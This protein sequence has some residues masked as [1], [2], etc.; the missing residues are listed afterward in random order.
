MSGPRVALRW[1]R[2][3]FRLEVDL[4]LPDR[5]LTALTGPSGS[6]KTTLLRCIAGLER[7]DGRVEFRG[8]VWQAEDRFLPPHRRSVGYVFQ[9]AS[10][11][12]HLDVAGNLRFAL[13][14]ARRRPP[15]LD[16][17]QAVALF[18][19]APLLSRRPA[20]LSGGERQRV[21]LART[22]LVAPEWL[23]MDEP[24]ASLDAQRK[25][26]ILPFLERL[27]ARFA[28]PVLYV[29]HDL[30]EIARLADHLVVLDRGQ[31]VAQGAPADLAA[32]L[33]LVG[34]LGEE[35]AG[36]VEGRVAD[37]DGRWHLLR[38]NFAG[39][40]LWV[41]DGGQALGERVRLRVLARD[42]SVALSP[43]TDS[44]ILNCFPA[45]VEAFADDVHPALALL[46]LRAGQEGEG[47]PFLAR[48]T[49]RSLHALGLRAGRTVWAQ[50]KSA[51]VLE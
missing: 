44:S 29:S 22:L 31:V 14:R 47:A 18:E 38:V 4:A 13:K 25:R 34:A 43:A 28:L 3:G 21:A 17:A 8:D 46:R 49:R 48:L 45:R 23:L 40:S 27:Q 12:D 32:R 6:G 20:T 26:D 1:V 19:L 7:A 39:G 33:D 10:L 16:F 35:P 2:P 9:E 50:V 51:A 30:D 5:C 37:R 24:L 11:F 41:R 42:V 36:L 15:L